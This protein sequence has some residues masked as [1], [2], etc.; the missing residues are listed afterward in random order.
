MPLAILLFLAQVASF[1]GWPSER[2]PRRP[3]PSS[4]RLCGCHSR[5]WR[6]T[7]SPF[8]PE[9]PC[10][11][12]AP[13]SQPRRDRMLFCFFLGQFQGGFPVVPRVGEGEGVL[14]DSSSSSKRRTS[15]S[16]GRA[17]VQGWLEA[18]APPGSSRVWP[19]G[20]NHHFNY[21]LLLRVGAVYFAERFSLFS[22]RVHPN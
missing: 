5:R 20:P 15:E 10:P 8:L 14:G 9:L 3:A 19:G 4:E 11:A 18:P 2:L 12:R 17:K 13:G 16:V 7:Q 6:E 22:V 21:S 1:L